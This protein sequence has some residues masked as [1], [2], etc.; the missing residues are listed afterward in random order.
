MEGAPSLVNLLLSKGL[1]L[2]LPTNTLIFAARPR[3]RRSKASIRR[4]R[5]G[6][7]VLQP[8]GH[9]GGLPGGRGHGVVAPAEAGR[10]RGRGRVP[11]RRAFWVPLAR[12]PLLR[13]LLHAHALSVFGTSGRATA[14]EKPRIRGDAL[15]SGV[16]LGL[17]LGGLAQVEG[18]AP[19]LEAVLRHLRRGFLLVAWEAEEVDGR[20]RQELRIREQI[21]VV[22]HA[23]RRDQQL[24]RAAMLEECHRVRRRHEVVLL[25]VDEEGRTGDVA[26]E[27]NVGKTLVQDLGDEAADQRLGRLADGGEGR[28]QDEAAHRKPAREVHRRPGAHGTAE[29]NDLLVRDSQL[30][31][32]EPEGC[33]G[34]LLQRG[35]RRGKT[36]KKAIARVLH[37]Q[38]VHLELVPHVPHERKAHTEVLGVPVAEEDDT[39]RLRRGQP[40][41]RDALGIPLVVYPVRRNGLVPRDPTQ[42]L[43]ERVLAIGR[44]RRREDQ[45][46][47]E[48]GHGK[49]QNN[50]CL[51]C[52]RSEG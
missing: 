9:C 2:V 34:H 25:P 21:G 47:D 12:R 1:R 40:H 20:H 48:A 52:S 13:L 23:G 18:L 24:P 17:P 10:F 4:R 15:V 16:H 51:G 32:H 5:H 36:M 42:V 38:H 6:H 28:H 22:L 31:Q 11:L 39:S 43:F 19:I 50:A 29:Q 44:R 49:R 33:E 41:A 27:R 45:F 3:P 35:L 8:G 30:V 46:I 37:S 26:Y 14:Q 7:T